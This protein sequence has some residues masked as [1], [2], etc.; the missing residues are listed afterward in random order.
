MMLISRKRYNSLS[1]PLLYLNATELEQVASY[2]YLGVIITTN[3][4]WQLHVTSMCKKA[5]KLIGMLY[6][7]FYEHSSSNTLLKLYLTTIRPH[8]EYASP[9]WSPF[10]KREIEDIESV[11]KYALRMCLKSWNSNYEELL[12]NTHIPTLSS[13]RTRASMYHLFKIINKQTH[14][15]AAP[16][17][18]RKIPYNSRTINQNTIMI[19][20]ANTAAYQFSFFPRSLALWNIL[21][22]DNT[23]CTKLNIFKQTISNIS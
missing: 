20:K 1:P 22:E 8:L 13:R 21:P 18:S 11:Q 9:V 15:P 14:F 7:N 19:P 5:R 16:I 17:A 10:H 23:S 6:R 2:K 4:S 3:L 12:E